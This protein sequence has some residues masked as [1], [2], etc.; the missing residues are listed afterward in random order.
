MLELALD[1]PITTLSAFGVRCASEFVEFAG[2]GAGMEGAFG[3]LSVL[4]IEFDEVLDTV[5][6]ALVE[7]FPWTEPIKDAGVANMP[8]K[9]RLSS[10]L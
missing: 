2:I 3:V 5:D 6:A 7:A 10:R 9:V 1:C 8:S 4:E